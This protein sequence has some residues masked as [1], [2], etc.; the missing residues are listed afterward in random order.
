MFT[1][2]IPEMKVL[3]I[4][5]LGSPSSAIISALIFNAIIIP[6]LIPLAMRGVSYKPMSSIKLLRKNIFIYGL[7]GILVPFLGIKLIDLLVSIW[8]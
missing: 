7:G 8:I 4:M 1:L 6:L 3:N 5:G 2:A